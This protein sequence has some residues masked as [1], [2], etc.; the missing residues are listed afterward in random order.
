ML[1]QCVFTRDWMSLCVGRATECTIRQR[2][3]SSGQLPVYHTGWNL[4]AILVLA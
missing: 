2:V 1:W 4:L 3:Y